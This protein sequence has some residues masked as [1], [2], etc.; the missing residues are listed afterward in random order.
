MAGLSEPHCT[1]IANDYHLYPHL[2]SS[3]VCQRI[4]DAPQT[5][6]LAVLEESPPTLPATRLCTLQLEWVPIQLTL[7]H[8]AVSA[9]EIFA[10][11]ARQALI[12]GP[13]ESKR[14]CLDSR[15]TR[16]Q[17]TK[18]HQQTLHFVNKIT[19][20]HLHPL[21]KKTGRSCVLVCSWAKEV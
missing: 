12:T 10:G 14:C 16:T 17:Q 8:H 11:L 21:T 18:T 6:L 15:R 1:R 7:R 5:R 3:W 2:T 20:E 9:A 4:A 13:C 19:D